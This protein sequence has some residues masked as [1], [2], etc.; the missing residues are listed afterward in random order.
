MNSDPEK[1]ANPLQIAG[2][3]ID[4][5]GWADSL[6]K[7]LDAST[8][9]TVSV[10]WI[11][12]NCANIARD[13][14]DYRRAIAG[15][16]FVLNDGVGIEIAGRWKR[17]PVVDNLCGTDWIPA[18]L[19]RLN[20]Q[21]DSLGR[22]AI[23]GGREDVLAKVPDLFALRWPALE[24]VFTHHGYFESP[25][26]ILDR[27]AV[28]QPDVLLLTMGVPLQEKFADKHRDQLAAAGVKVVIAGGAVI[29]YL[30]DSV[31][32]APAVVRRAKMEWVYRLVREPSRLWRRYILGT[33]R[34]LVR[35]LASGRGPD[36]ID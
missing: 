33:L 21:P 25:G 14:S 35:L 1:T 23:V 22:I 5:L 9:G 7:V 12:A 16:D 19:D 27:L 6:Q 34:F 17:R 26:P 11:Y 2:L 3:Q 4:R 28:A 24:L 32:R 31:P 18:L 8:Q 30:T 10:G 29:D 13:D 20:D 15:L 36:P